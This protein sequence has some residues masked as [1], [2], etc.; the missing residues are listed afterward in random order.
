MG[1]G[2][3][4]LARRELVLAEDPSQGLNLD[5]GE[6]SMVHMLGQHSFAPPRAIVV[7][8]EEPDVNTVEN[9]RNCD[10]STQNSKVERQFEGKI[11][12]NL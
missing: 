9:I 12:F 5:I 2:E 3:Q 11:S 6:L 10:L 4:V 7:P 1:E 8:I